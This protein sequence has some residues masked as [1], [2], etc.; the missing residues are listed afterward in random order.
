MAS[1]PRVG[2]GFAAAALGHL[3]KEFPH[4]KEQHHENSLRELTFGTRHK[5]DA[6]RAQRGDAHEEILAEGFSVDQSL[7]GF[8]QCVPAH[9]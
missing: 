3:F 8:L 1:E 4:L 5:A 9:Y 6:Q 2:N 7:G